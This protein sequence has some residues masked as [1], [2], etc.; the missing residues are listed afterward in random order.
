[1]TMIVKKRRI[2]HFPQYIP[3]KT[4]RKQTLSLE[5]GVVEFKREWDA[6]LKNRELAADAKFLRRLA[7]AVKQMHTLALNSKEQEKIV[8][9]VQTFLA[10]SCG[11]TTLLQAADSYGEE[12]PRNSDL[13][14][15][16]SEFIRQQM[17]LAKDDS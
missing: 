15:L 4:R 9:D 7:I 6:L 16:L 11:E 1:M 3:L 12:E 2:L 10:I 5:R 13:S 8:A 17:Q 14:Q